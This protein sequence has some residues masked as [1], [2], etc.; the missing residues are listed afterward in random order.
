[1]QASYE[2][3]LTQQAD[4]VLPVTIW[5]E[6]EGTYINLDGHIQ[7][8]TKILASPE[9]VHDNLTVLNDLAAQMNISLNSNWK[10]AILARQSSV[11]L[12]YRTLN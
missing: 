6:Q 9:T 1:V 11:V 8:T 10:E 2:S 12:N 3:E 4:V 5:S 7:N